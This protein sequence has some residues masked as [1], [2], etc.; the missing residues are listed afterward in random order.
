M[1]MGDNLTFLSILKSL[2]QLY[3]ICL[4]N[5]TKYFCLLLKQTYRIK[6]QWNMINLVSIDPSA[7][8][9]TSAE[10]QENQNQSWKHFER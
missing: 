3:H 4:P 1:E 6:H 8:R 10:L 2:R 7:L 9:G 5:Y